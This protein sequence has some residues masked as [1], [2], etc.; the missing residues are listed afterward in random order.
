[1]V[2]LVLVE[3]EAAHQGVDGAVA[4]VQRDEGAFDLGDLGDLPGVLG[5]LHDADHRAAPDLDL[6]RR[7][8]RQAGLRGPQALAHDLDPVAVER[9]AT[10]F[11]GSSTTAARRR[12]CR[13]GRPGRR[14]SR[15][16]A[17]WGRGQVDEALGAAVDL[18]LLVVHDALAQRLVGGLL[19]V[20]LH[21]GE[22]V[23]AARVGVV[24]VLRVHQ[25]AHRLRDVFGAD[26]GGLHAGAHPQLL[27]LG[28]LACSAV[29]KP[30]SSIRSMM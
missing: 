29:M 25:L 28:C 4:R 20:R 7:L 2:E 8:L 13:D 1:M 18:A 14:R 21:G 23:Q 9:T 15:L 22:D 16:P 24:A 11:F 3:V 6:G 5:R 12:R 27:L 10:I 26:R 17:P 30:F 19:L